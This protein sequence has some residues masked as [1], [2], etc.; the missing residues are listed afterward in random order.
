MFEIRT[1]NDSRW[2][3]TQEDDNEKL[4]RS[5][6]GVVVLVVAYFCG[7]WGEEERIS[8]GEYL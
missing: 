7:Q 8:H 4:H 1:I 3:R 6:L 5:W 2:R